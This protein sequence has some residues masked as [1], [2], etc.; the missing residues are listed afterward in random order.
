MQK[1]TINGSVYDGHCLESDDR[2]FVYLDGLTIMD[3]FRIFS[4]PDNYATIHEVSYGVERDY[5][6]YNTLIAVNGEY[7]N[8]NVTLK[9]ERMEEPSNEGELESTVS[10]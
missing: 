9:R 10:E 6:G 7:G 2:L 4:D 5:T 3:G 1:L 8:C